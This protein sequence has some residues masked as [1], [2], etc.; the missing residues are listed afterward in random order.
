M[1]TKI[2]KHEYRKHECLNC[3]YIQKIKTNHLSGCIDYCKNCSWKPSFGKDI[4][5]KMFSCQ[6]Y[7]R[8]KYVA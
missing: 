5:I 6:A 4:A 1:D 8:F 2:L 7:R 3:G